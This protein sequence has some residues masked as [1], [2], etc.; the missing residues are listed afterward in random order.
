MTRASPWIVT[1]WNGST[2]TARGSEIETATLG[3]ARMCASLREN[4]IEEWNQS[5]EPS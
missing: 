4:R 3:F 5:L 1:R 2:G